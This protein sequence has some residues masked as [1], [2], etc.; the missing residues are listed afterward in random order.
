MGRKMQIAL[1]DTLPQSPQDRAPDVVEHMHRAARRA[2]AL[3]VEYDGT[4]YAGFQLQAKAPTV[5]GELER[6]VFQLTRAPARVRG[7][8]RTDRGVHARGQ[9]VA[10]S[11]DSLL[12]CDAFEKGL[13]HFLPSDIGVKAAYHVRAPFDP[14]RQAISRV[15]RYTFLDSTK[16]SPLQERYAH[17][18]AQRL[19]DEAMKN[20]LRSLEGERDFAL[21]SGTVAPGKSTVRRVYATRLWRDENLVRIEVEANAFLPHQMRRIAGLLV[22][23]G[24]G[25]MTLE[26][27]RGVVNGNAGPL[28]QA[29]NVCTMPP[30]GLCLMQVKYED[31]PP[32][33]HE[34]HEDV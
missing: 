34:T 32:N 28:L 7:A 26:G 27:V 11:T 2:V 16:R 31:F 24:T 13:N 10:F 1:A 8:G 19:D 9:V 17:R 22:A 12:A 20:A 29:A 23:V 14:R 25:R 5:Q 30:Q 6:A 3:V 4:R 18:V 15:Y 21:L 33:G